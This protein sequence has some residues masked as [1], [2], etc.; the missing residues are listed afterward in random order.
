MTATYNFHEKVV[1]SQLNGSHIEFG[2]FSYLKKC[3]CV[4]IHVLDPKSS[5]IKQLGSYK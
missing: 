2:G 3:K 1:F 4:L 5:T